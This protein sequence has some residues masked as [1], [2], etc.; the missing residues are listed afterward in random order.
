MVAAA[1]DGKK[2]YD[3]HYS[4]VAG[5][6]GGW[7]PAASPTFTGYAGQGPSLQ[8]PTT[9]RATLHSTAC[10]PTH[11]SRLAEGSSASGSGDMVPMDGLMGSTVA[12]Q[13]L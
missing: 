12:G 1:T 2:K 5:S 7:R 3:Q 6:R 9:G 11:P 8:F 13:L 10:A 4:N